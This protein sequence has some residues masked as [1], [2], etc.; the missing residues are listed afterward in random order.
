MTIHPHHQNFLPDLTWRGLLHQ[1]THEEELSS[2]LS[3]ATRSIY[4]GFD[5]TADSLTIGNLIPI[6]LLK[7]AQR[8]GHIPIVIVGGGTGLI[9]DPSGKSSERTLL[10]P[11]TV[12]NNV[13]GQLRIFTQILDFNPGLYQAKCINNLDWLQQLSYLDLLRDIG[14]HF[15][16]NAMIQRD[17]VKERL[18]NREQGI[19]YTEFSYMVLQSYDF[20]HLAKHQGVSIQMGGSDQF[21]NI[22]SGC[23]LIR[24]MLPNQPAFGITA[25]LLTKADGGKFGKTEKG[26]IWLTADRTS[27]YQFYQFF[28]NTEDQDIIRFL[29]IFTFL[30][31]EEITI[32]EQQH[33]QN[34]GARLAHQTLAKLVTEM[35]H[36]KAAAEQAERASHA[37]FT[38]D[39]V[40]LP[41][42]FFEE[43]FAAIPTSEYPKTVIP[44]EGMNSVD[45]FMLTSLVKSK[46]EARELL[47][48]GSVM[49]NGVRV[50]EEYRLLPEQ[51]LH[52][53]LVAIR[54]GKKHWFL[55]RFL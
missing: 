8:A 41:Q 14:K 39:I 38:G 51:L 33:I 10:D 49:I 46:R 32:L 40:H 20:Y 22:V 11:E 21:G 24:R 1:A 37:L 35:V 12:A 34:P 42:P 19:S 2:Y 47:A 52:G 28:I 13:R 15:S 45:V 30:S 16:V 36:G 44:A 27:P 48:A 17:S 26:A 53:S 5:P 55:I 9:G 23:D 18:H 54:K 29:K 43:I 4:A 7:H 6:L 50:S 25:P 31:Q 3:I